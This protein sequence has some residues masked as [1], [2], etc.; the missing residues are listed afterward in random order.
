MSGH[1]LDD[2]I[3][4]DVIVDSL[5]P[6]TD[7]DNV[8]DADDVDEHFRDAVYRSVKRSTPADRRRRPRSP[9][10]RLL[11]RPGSTDRRAETVIYRPTR[12]PESV[13]RQGSCAVC[14]DT[15]K[16]TSGLTGDI[17]GRPDLIDVCLRPHTTSS[18]HTDFAHC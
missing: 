17:D 9:S 18:A 13:Y 7:N 10:C 15:I 11:D 2:V 4:S 8:D 14:G 3:T 1:L 5:P 12:A 6:F 16:W